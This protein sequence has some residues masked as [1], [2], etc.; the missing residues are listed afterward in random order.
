[1]QSFHQAHKIKKPDFLDPLNTVW[2]ACKGI[3]KRKFL[4]EYRIRFKV[5]Y[6]SNKYF[7][8]YLTTKRFFQTDFAHFKVSDETYKEWLYKQ[9]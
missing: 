3:P 9:T 4:A 1:M 5:G 2:H 7:E 6:A 8:D